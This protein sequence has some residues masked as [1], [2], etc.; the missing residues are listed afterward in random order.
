MK[1][2]SSKVIDAKKKLEKLVTL[3]KSE[4]KQTKK[5]AN[6]TN[7]ISILKKNLQT[8]KQETKNFFINFVRPNFQAKSEEIATSQFRKVTSD[9]VQIRDLVEQLNILQRN[10]SIIKD[11]IEFPTELLTLFLVGAMGALGSI[12]YLS[13]ILIDPTKTISFAFCFFRPLYGVLIALT[14]FIVLKAGVLVITDTNAVKETGVPLNPF[15]VSFIGI[16]SGL[17]SDQAIERIQELGQE[18]LKSSH[19]GRPRW[20]TGV[21][22]AIEQSSE[23]GQE[24]KPEEL[25]RFFPENHQLINQWISQKEPTPVFAQQI[26]AAWLNMEVR[27]LFSDIPPANE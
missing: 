6:E 12:C 13:Q 2:L 19:L 7:N 21:M 14:V 8:K 1:L 11:A 4:K 16:I 27:E 17:L 5:V 22:N 20:A 15:F 18:W 9:A 10:F 26:I 23:K 24:K 3:W 25:N